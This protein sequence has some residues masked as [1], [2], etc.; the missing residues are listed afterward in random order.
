[1]ASFA[2]SLILINMSQPQSSTSLFTRVIRFLVMNFFNSFIKEINGIE[3]LPASG[4]YILA[5]NHLNTL[6]AFFIVSALTLRTKRMPY[7]IAKFAPWG[8]WWEKAVVQGWANCIPLRQPYDEKNKEKSL[9]TA[10]EYLKQGEIVG[11]FPES[12]RNLEP[13]LLK[14]KTGAARLALWAKAPVVPVGY[15][16]PAIASQWKTIGK[17]MFTTGKIKMNIGQ[18]LYFDE[19]YNRAINEEIL[20]EINRKIMLSIGQLCGKSYPY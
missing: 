20:N 1:M 16:G 19:Y 13:Y 12:Q 6:D 3:H 4:P 15:F 8:Q 14:G 5:V 9:M 17:V 10:L 2:T 7:F 18:P 11:I